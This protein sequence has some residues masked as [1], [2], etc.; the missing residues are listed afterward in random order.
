M[1]NKHHNTRLFAKAQL[2]K[3]GFTILDKDFRV[4]QYC[5]IL[6]VCNKVFKG[7]PYRL[8]TGHTT[9]C[10]CIRAFRKRRGTPIEYISRLLIQ[11]NYKCALS[12]LDIKIYY[13]GIDKQTNTASL[14]RIDNAKGYTEDNIQW[15]HKDI[16]WLKQD[17]TQEYFIKLC[18]KVSRKCKSLT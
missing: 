18:H 6:C 1:S 12:G 11:Q 3:M 17:F 5:N 8:L 14:D 16:N 2:S 13:G 4:S 15:V 7:R 9:S 10:G